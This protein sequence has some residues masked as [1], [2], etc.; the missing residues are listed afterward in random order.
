MSLYE[1]QKLLNEYLLFHYGTSSELN[2]F[3]FIKESHLHFPER[4]VSENLDSS[5]SFKR[6]LDLGC[7]VGRSSFE[8]S[9]FCED[10]LAIDNSRMFIE[11]AE[12]LRLNASLKYHIHTEGNEVIETFAKVPKASKPKKVR[13]QVGDAMTLSDDI[14]QFD[15]IHAANLICRLPEPKKLL[16]RFPSLLNTGGLLIITTPCTWLGEFTKPDYWPESSTLDWL[17]DSLSPQLVLN[18]VKDM[19]FVILEHHRK[20]QYSLAQATIWSLSLIHI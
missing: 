20:Y 14:G 18:E 2:P 6:A 10:V 15:V 19:P 16:N 17:K 12:N 3:G 9:S 1:T 5:K 8:L 7:S 4:T 13:F 11:N